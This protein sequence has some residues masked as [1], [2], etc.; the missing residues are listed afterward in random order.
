MQ[1]NVPLRMSL[2]VGLMIVLTL[3][4]APRAAA[5][6]VPTPTSAA[7][8]KPAAPTPTHTVTPMQTATPT[9]TVTPDG[10]NR[11]MTALQAA[12]SPA[13]DG[14]LVDWQAATPTLLTAANASFIQGTLDDDADLSAGLRAAWAPDALYFAASITD[15]ILI[16][17][18]SEKIW[19]DDTLE[20]GIRTGE[21]THQ[22]TVAVDG[23]QA[24]QGVEI[25]ALT[26]ATRTVTGGWNVEVKIPVSMLGLA[27]VSAGQELPFSWA[28]W[29]DDLGATFG[30][31]HMFWADASTNSY[32]QNWGKLVNGAAP[33]VFPLATSTPTPT[34]TAT[35]TNTS[36]PTP[37]STPTAT[38]TPTGTPTETPTPTSSPTA[39]YTPT[40]TATATR[41][42]GCDCPLDPFEPD[43]T[44]PQARPLSVQGVP[45]IHSLHQVTD[46]DWYRLDGLTAGQFYRVATSSLTGSADTLMVLYRDGV[47]VAQNDD[48]N[49]VR[50]ATDPQACASAILWQAADSGPY[51]L[52]VSAVNYPPQKPPSC[53]CPG[54]TIAAVLSGPPTLTPTATLTPTSTVTPSPTATS[55]PKVFLP[56]ILR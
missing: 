51:F 15:D 37:T 7:T 54:Y 10:L 41:P 53:P 3:A 20:L 5:T 46:V 42:G 24:Y 18:N 52:A 55:M 17:N 26:V 11:S 48:V 33:I 16:G 35:P 29:D 49:P 34:S 45:Q 21:T 25:T 30:Q 23:R 1:L 44:L 43:D 38:A 12:G 32:N 13:L 27:T 56:L 40:P 6:A 19:G 9:V 4:A 39:T 8:A 2:S 36:T 22:F 28:L 14:N 47:E 50:C 31:T